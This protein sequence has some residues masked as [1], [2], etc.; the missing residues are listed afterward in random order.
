MAEKIVLIDGN[1]IV[2]RAFYGLPDLT[3]SDGTHTNGILGFLN[4]ML[5]ILDEEKPGYLA[6]A[7]DVKHPTFRHERYPE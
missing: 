1:S 3:A 6:V 7:F 2:N 5:R 4:I